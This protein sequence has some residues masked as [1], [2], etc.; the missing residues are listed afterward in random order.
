[1]RI[2]FFSKQLKDKKKLNNKIKKMLN[3]LRITIRKVKVINDKNTQTFNLKID[4]FKQ[5]QELEKLSSQSETELNKVFIIS[6]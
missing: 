2:N 3:Y 6:K 4:L 1:L 5:T